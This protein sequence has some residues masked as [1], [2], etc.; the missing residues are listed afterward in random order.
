MSDRVLDQGLPGRKIGISHFG[1]SC[2]D[3]DNMLDFYT[4][5]VGLTIADQ[6]RINAGGGTD[7]VFLTTDPNEHHQLVLASGRRDTV[8]ETT[9]VD[10]GSIGSNVFQ[11]S[12]RVRDLG[13]LRQLNRRLD[14][15]NLCGQVAMDHGNAWSLYVRDPEGNGL[16]FFVD[17]PWYVAQPC[18]ETFDLEDPDD[19]ILARTEAYVRSQPEGQPV[20]EWSAA[21][22]ERILREQ[23]QL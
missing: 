4:R 23:E 2:L 17:S 15:E 13:T 1:V 21:L 19:V 10:G 8:V 14:N 11:V 20:E 18:A 12:F 7:L 22:A 6:G 16:E 3:F 5:V 9:P